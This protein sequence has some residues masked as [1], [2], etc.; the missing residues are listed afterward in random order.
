MNFPLTNSLLWITKIVRGYENYMKKRL[1]I[2]SILGILILIVAV[3]GAVYLVQ[4][5]Q[6][7]ASR[8]NV[9]AV[10]QNVKVTN[11]N[12]TGFTVTWMT[13]VKSTGVITVSG[14]D[15]ENLTF[16]D[17][18]GSSYVHSADASGLTP[19][20]TYSVFG[21]T[22]AQTTGNPTTS[23]DTSSGSVFTAAGT[24]AKKTLVFWEAPGI[25]TLS[26]VTSDEGNYV[27]PIGVA[28][29]DTLVTLTAQAGPEGVSRAE[30]YY[31][32]VKNLPPMVLG[33][34]HDFKNLTGD[35]VADNS[36][37]EADLQAPVPTP[38]TSVAPETILSLNSFIADES[39]NQTTT[40]VT[41]DSLAEG[42]TVSA[43]RPEFF[44]TAPVKTEITLTLESEMQTDNITAG[45][46][47]KW[48]WSPDKTIAEGPHKI[49]LSWKDTNGI[50][51]TITR[52]FVVSAA[53]QNPGFISTPSASLSPEPDA[54]LP[55]QPESGVGTPF[56]LLLGASIALIVSGGYLYKLT[57]YQ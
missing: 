35:E 31:R 40:T 38:E 29:D 55:P 36:V 52:N 26:T 47:G 48:S 50:L 6:Q 24:P 5:Q 45:S 4:R 46:S 33:Q 12:N 10:P 11:N 25:T 51:K 41:L 17:S 23:T 13:K 57:N 37:P 30:I 9:E 7:L 20:T 8:A 56:I 1:T 14:P 34:I 43:T 28:P 3:T 18:I 15:S 2:P 19:N 27:I 16:I 42:E 54:T 22:Q 21:S 44:G 39:L 53:E 32:A 49:T